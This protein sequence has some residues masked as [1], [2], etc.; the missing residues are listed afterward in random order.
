MKK[1]IQQYDED[2]KEQIEEEDTSPTCKE[3]TNMIFASYLEADSKRVIYYDL[4]GK[5]PITSIQGNKYILL[6][7]HYN[8]NKIIVRALKNRSDTETLKVYKEIYKLLTARGFNPKLHTLDNKAS[9]LLKTQITKNGTKYQLVEPHNHRVLALEC[10]IITFKNHF[11]TV[12][13]STDPNFLFY[14][15]DKLLQQAEITLNLLLNSRQH[16]Q[17]SAHAYMYGIFDYNKM[18]LAPPGTKAVVFK[19]PDTI[20]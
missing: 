12:L 20:S 1:I 9:R 8:S 4:I 17:L 16:P 14:L 13:A 7:Y 6:V 5:F 2:S 19:D 18:L 11:I 10:C 3:R 15:W